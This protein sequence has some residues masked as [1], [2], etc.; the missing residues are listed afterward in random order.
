MVLDRFFSLKLE[1][2]FVDQA[3]VSGYF[4]KVIRASAQKANAYSEIAERWQRLNRSDVAQGV[5]ERAYP[6]AYLESL[7][8]AQMFRLPL[9]IPHPGPSPAACHPPR[10]SADLPRGHATHA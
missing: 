7:T 6:A 8:N 3:T 10:G 1:P 2:R 5:V 9:P 4:R